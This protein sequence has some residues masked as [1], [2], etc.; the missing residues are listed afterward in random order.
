LRIVNVAFVGLAFVSEFI[1]MLATW[2]KTRVPLCNVYTFAQMI[3]GLVQRATILLSAMFT[4]ILLK[5]DS[6]INLIVGFIVGICLVISQLMVSKSIITGLKLSND[7]LMPNTVRCFRVSHAAGYFANA[8]AYKRLMVDPTASCLSQ[9]TDLSTKLITG[10]S[11]SSENAATNHKSRNKG[12]K[13][14]GLRS[15]QIFLQDIPLIIGCPVAA[16]FNLVDKNLLLIAFGA[17]ILDLVISTIYLAH[18]EKV[19]VDA[20]DVFESL[21]SRGQPA[22]SVH[23]LL[24]PVKHEEISLEFKPEKTVT[25]QLELAGSPEIIE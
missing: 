21:E 15:W 1:L 2:S 25:E 12:C 3:A 17:G 18:D 8:I 14:G 10:Q 9:G 16:A 6:K 23:F 11:T 24:P 13:A 4:A 5:D 22:K 19:S 7:S 20:D